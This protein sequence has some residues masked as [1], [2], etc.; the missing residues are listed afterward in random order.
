MIRWLPALSRRVITTSSR[1][2]TNRSGS[3]SR[4]I[5]ATFASPRHRAGVPAG[6]SLL[7]PWI[8]TR[9]SR[10]KSSPLTELG[11]EPIRSSPPSIVTSV[12]LIRGEPSLRMVAIVRCLRAVKRARERAAKS[13]SVASNSAHEATADEDT[14]LAS[15]YAAT[16]WRTMRSRARAAKRRCIATRIQGQMSPK[17]ASR[18]AMKSQPHESAF[19]WARALGK[20]RIT[21]RITS[22]MTNAWTGKQKLTVL[23]MIDHGLLPLV[24]FG[25]WTRKRVRSI[26][27]Y[28]PL[29]GHIERGLKR[30][31][32]GNG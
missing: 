1:S 30:L 27:P 4:A 5:P 9:G 18:I 10:R 21:A 7:G 26:L 25:L 22:A 16:T 28:L 32:R 12:P 13:G 31:L 2:I 19:T 15:G 20:N 23:A 11:I 8:A 6:G 29:G 17:K 24:R 14:R 3:T